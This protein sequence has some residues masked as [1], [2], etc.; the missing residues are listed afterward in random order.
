MVCPCC[1]P[2][3]APCSCTAIAEAPGAL[4]AVDFSATSGFL[5]VTASGTLEISDG[6]RATATA[7]AISDVWRN[8]GL[9][10]NSKN[11]APQQSLLSAV[12]DFWYDCASRP[13]LR[14]YAYD[15]YAVSPNGNG[16]AGC[17]FCECDEFLYQ[18]VYYVTELRC[19]NF[20]TRTLSSGGVIDSSQT[21][22]FITEDGT[23][24]NDVRYPASLKTTT[25]TFSYNF[26]EA[27]YTDRF[28]EPSNQSYSG[29]VKLY[30]NELP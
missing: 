17:I 11:P 5:G 15:A 29:F 7:R 26:T 6:C 24:W 27:V 22:A 18:G 1:V 10:T 12:C 28:C 2:P 14:L 30:F 23:N 9:C 20:S 21:H 13:R 19:I 25:D 4:V 8:P 3:V 16:V